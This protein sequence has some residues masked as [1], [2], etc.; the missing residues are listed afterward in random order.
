MEHQVN[1]TPEQYFA[2][3]CHRDNINLLIENTILKARDERR[4]L[5]KEDFEEMIDV[6]LQIL[7]MAMKKENFAQQQLKTG[8]GL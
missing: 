2:L 3:R 7:E 1:L 8:W 5:Q 4:S 6:T